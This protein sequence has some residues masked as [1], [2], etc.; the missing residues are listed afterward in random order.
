MNEARVCPKCRS[1]NI[2][3]EAKELLFD[4]A[5]VQ[6]LFVCQKCGFSSS[7]FPVTNLKEKKNFKKA[8]KKII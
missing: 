6:P 3:R 8:L 1:L 5:G 7:I 2:R 4:L